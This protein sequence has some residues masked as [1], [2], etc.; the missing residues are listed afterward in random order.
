MRKL[1]ELTF[2]TL[3]GVISDPQAWGPPYWDEE[4]GEHAGKQLFASEALLLGRATYESF[5][6]VWPTR[7]GHF[8]DKFNDMPKYVASRTPR[9]LTWN[10]TQLQ[11]DLAGAVAEVKAGPGGGIIKYGTGEAD[12]E[13]LKHKLVDEY[14]FWFF[15][16]IA[17]AGTR[18]FE[19]FDA[20]T[21]LA[22]TGTTTLKSGIVIHTYVPK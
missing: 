19:G 21:H 6:G 4:H 12:H 20:V 13:L 7:S 16:V 18:L 14:H 17:G 22:L 11:G 9:E 3:D 10:A 1:I 15:P 8:A 2:V 5:A